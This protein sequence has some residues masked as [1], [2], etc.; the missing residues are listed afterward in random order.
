V[1]IGLE[2][3]TAGGGTITTSTKPVV[4]RDLFTAEAQQRIGRKLQMKYPHGSDLLRGAAELLK[5]IK[6]TETGFVFRDR[7]IALATRRGGERTELAK[8]TLRL[9][10]ARKNRML[11]TG[12]GDLAQAETDIL[13]A[14]QQYE[15]R[16]NPPALVV[17]MGP[18][19]AAVLQKTVGALFGNAGTDMYAVEAGPKADQILIGIADNKAQLER[20]IRDEEQMIRARDDMHW[21]DCCCRIMGGSENADNERRVI[22]MLISAGAELKD[23]A[24]VDIGDLTEAHVNAALSAVCEASGIDVVSPQLYTIVGAICR[25]SRDRAGLPGRLR[26]RVKGG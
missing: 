7:A 13:T 18:D 22:D 4:N 21:F 16:K 15:E 19:G 1:F 5:D 24:G 2:Q 23:G 11:A 17:R 20:A 6:P 3:T 9:G 26:A 25:E 10:I 12:Q 14:T 8:L